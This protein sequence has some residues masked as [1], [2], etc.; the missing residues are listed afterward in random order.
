MLKNKDFK[1]KKL[2]DYNKVIIT[3]GMEFSELGN[4]SLQNKENLELLRKKLYLFTGKKLKEIV[5]FGEQTEAGIVD[6][7]KNELLDKDHYGDMVV[8]KASGF[9]S[10]YSESNTPIC[11]RIHQNDIIVSLVNNRGDKVICKLDINKIE[12]LRRIIVTKL[13][14]K[15]KKSEIKAVLY[16]NRDAIISVKEII[17]FKEKLKKLRLREEGLVKYELDRGYVINIPKLFC[18]IL[19]KH[20]VSNDIQIFKNEEEDINNLL[21][22][23]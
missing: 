10:A 4:Y 22:F 21:L 23:L 17:N 1:S 8:M 5:A 9:S 20:D 19:F 14:N 7:E 3:R 11:T 15:E 13:E 2:G 18:D 6:I 12:K 16:C